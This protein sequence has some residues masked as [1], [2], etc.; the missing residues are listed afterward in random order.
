MNGGN[1]DDKAISGEVDDEVNGRVGDYILIGGMGR[2]TFICHRFDQLTHFLEE[3]NVG[4][5]CEMRNSLDLGVSNYSK[6]SIN[7]RLDNF[8]RNICYN[9]LI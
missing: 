5:Q 8:I 7:N 3:D 2:D 1:G 6:S 4:R 9:D